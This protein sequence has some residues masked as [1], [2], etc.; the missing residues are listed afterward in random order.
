MTTSTRSD[1]GRALQY[2]LG[3]TGLALILVAASFVAGAGDDG[4]A[5]KALLVIA[6]LVLALVEGV[7]IAGLRSEA[8]RVKRDVEGE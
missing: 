4:A 2:A 1:T 6:I 5:T 7:L 3:F 8:E